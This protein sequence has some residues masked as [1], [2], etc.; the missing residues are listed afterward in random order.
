MA[1]NLSLKQWLLVIAMLVGIFYN[2]RPE[3]YLA[4]DGSND[5]KLSAL[6]AVTVNNKPLALDARTKESPCQINGPLP[7][8]AC[9]PGAVFPNATAEQ[10]CVSGYTKTVRNVPISLKK[11]I[12]RD[13]DIAYPPPTGSYEADHLI[14]LELGGNNDIA[15]L[16]PEAAQPVPGFHEKDIVENYL[17]QKVCADRIGLA[18][19]QVQIAND[20]LAV[21]NTLTPDQIRQLKAQF[22]NWAN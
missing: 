5:T 20:W 1:P 17:H 2:T 21:Y 6:L 10:I 18:P 22:S 11:K 16:F 13:Y 12:Y 9:T 14:P 19:A 8:H 15:N 3:R 7:D 4:P